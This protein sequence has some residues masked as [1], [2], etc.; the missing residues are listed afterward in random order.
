MLRHRIQVAQFV[1]YDCFSTGKSVEETALA[2]VEKF[3]EEAINDYFY[4]FLTSLQG[5]LSFLEWV[6]QRLTKLRDHDLKVGYNK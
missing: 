5:D 2:V 4:G 6:E 1:L 3:P